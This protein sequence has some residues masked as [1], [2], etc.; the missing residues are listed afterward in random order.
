MKMANLCGS[1]R[2]SRAQA[3]LGLLHAP[4]NGKSPSSCSRDSCL[5]QASVPRAAPA[6]RHLEVTAGC[7]TKTH[8]RA[9]TQTSSHTSLF[10]KKKA[11]LSLGSFELD[12]Y[13]V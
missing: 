3:R 12:H 6:P 8:P 11:F 2:P 4:S 13:Y 1:A 7:Q 9:P 10:N 5:D